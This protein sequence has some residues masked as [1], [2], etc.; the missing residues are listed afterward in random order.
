MPVTPV[1]HFAFI[2][3]AEVVGSYS[4]HSRSTSNSQ[5]RRVMLWQQTTRILIQIL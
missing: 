1:H 2:L 3:T 5:N 4:Y